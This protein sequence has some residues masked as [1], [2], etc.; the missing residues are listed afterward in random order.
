MHDCASHDGY[1]S[2]VWSELK[3]MRRRKG[4]CRLYNMLRFWLCAMVWRF[5]FFLANTNCVCVWM[6]SGWFEE[7]WRINGCA[8]RRRRFE[9]TAHYADVKRKVVPLCG[10]GDG[11]IIMCEVLRLNFAP[12]VCED[13]YYME[14]VGGI[15][16]EVF[17]L[18]LRFTV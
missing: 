17:K 6:C 16:C 18:I 1:N 14:R 5:V 8:R 3:C 13:S 2:Q 10:G 15:L 12:L 11:I 7:H 4:C 9:R